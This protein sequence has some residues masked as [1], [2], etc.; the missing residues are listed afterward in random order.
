MSQEGIAII[1]MSGRFP[2]ARDVDAFWRNIRQGVESVTHFDASELDLP[3]ASLATEDPNARYICAKGILDDVDQFDA[4][5]FGYLPREAELMDPQHRMFLEICWEAMERAGHDPSRYPGAVGVYAGCYMDTY[6]MWNLC[7]DPAF[8]AR[9]IESIQVGSLQ[10]ELGNDKDYLATRVAFKLG[11]RGPAMTLQTACSTSLVAIATA[12]QSL[13]SYQCDMALAGGVTI[14]LPQKKGYFYKEGSM[15]SADGHCRTFDADAAGTVFSNGAAVVL[16]K[17]V[18]DAIADGDT[19]HAVIRGYA[20]NNDGAGKV[21][22]T[23]PSVD[24]QADVIS[25]ALA[26]GDIDARTVGLVEAHGTAT[27]MGDPIEIAGLTA[28]Y[29]AHTQDNQFC[30]IGSLKANLGHLDVASGAIGL[31][32]TALAVHEGVLPPSINFS[33]PNPKIDFASSPFYV[34]TAL[35]PWPQ[36][37]WPRRAGIS[38]FGVGGTNAH[39]VLEQAPAPAPEGARRSHA[40]LVLSARSKEA[41]SAQ[42]TR[43]AD[44]LEAHPDASLDDVAYTLQVGRQQFEHR[45]IV[46]AADIPGAIA[47]LRSPPAPGE[48]TKL[49]T[50]AARIAFMFP[51]QGAQYP[52][53]ARALHASEPAFRDIVDRCGEALCDAGMAVQDPRPLLLWDAAS[54]SLDAAQAAEAL[55][56]TDMAQPAIFTMEMALATLLAGWGVRAD[57]VL[58]HSVGEFAAA[59]LAGVFELEDAVRL[60]ATRGRLMQAQPQGTMLAVRAPLQQ[61]QPLLPDTLSIA[62]INAP[63]L[64]VASG[65]DDAIDA[66]AQALAAQ[67]IQATRLVTSHA[68]HSAMMAPARKPLEEAVAAVDSRPAAIPVV[69]TSTGTRLQADG[70]RDPAYWGAQLMRPVLFADAATEAA[71]DGLVL[72]EVGPGRTLSTLARQSLDKPGPLAVLPSLGPVQAPGSDVQHLLHAVGQL[73][74]G[75]VQPDWQALQPGPRRRVTLP[76]YPF[77]R[78]RFWV[79]PKALAS[80]GEGQVH[81]AATS[82]ATTAASHA[83]PANPATTDVEHLIRLQLSL[84]AEQ[85][86]AMG[87]TG[88][89]R[90]PG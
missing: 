46:V 50:A 79:Q 70:F 39:V 48:S 22:Y 41:L 88:T 37:E 16:L 53:M 42:A 15:L 78:K 66:F 83:L 84:I 7:S 21:S 24:G 49:D 73:W 33:K 77:E 28:A 61:V 59:C 31:I 14:V 65:P 72:L 60:V 30:A 27:P 80:Q 8:L 45:R 43:L 86:G 26:V 52:G 32:K 17:R 6:L 87:D 44:W 89:G 18:E 9:F 40:L 20:T 57:A 64:V 69:S 47:S 74:L 82:V 19:I 2:G 68:F 55:A 76:T 29:R 13:A 4:R 3:L 23:A 34:N 62:A 75:G 54:S 12:C 35:T 81:D 25:M 85:L 11:L 51:G 71:N 38:S 36:G 5:F 67:D 58:G 1:G 90:G 56:Q 10:T 63:G